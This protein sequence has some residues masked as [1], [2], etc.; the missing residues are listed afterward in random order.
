ME[1][2]VV[3][4][5]LYI[6]TMEKKMETTIVY[7]GVYWDNG[8]ENGNYYCILG[9]YGDNVSRSCLCPPPSTLLCK[10]ELRVQGMQ[11]AL[12]SSLLVLVI[13]WNLD[14]LSALKPHC[15]SS[16]WAVNC[17]V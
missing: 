17:K 9:V 3:Y 12:R 6:G 7:W 8:K 10:S 1:P 2:T 15:R 13:W 11:P 4:W 5:G 14:Q 16:S